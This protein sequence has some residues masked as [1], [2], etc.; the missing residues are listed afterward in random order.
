MVPEEH[1]LYAKTEPK[2]VTR[3]TVG[4][5]LHCTGARDISPGALE[6]FHRFYDFGNV[7]WPHIG[8]CPQRAAFAK[9]EDYRA[10]LRDMEK[11]LEDVPATET[12]PVR[13]LGLRAFR[14]AVPIENRAGA[15]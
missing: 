6:Q 4:Y 5:D 14:S 15:P 3:K 9:E 8:I 7:C 1:P 13:Y 2:P 12:L 10:A 11:R